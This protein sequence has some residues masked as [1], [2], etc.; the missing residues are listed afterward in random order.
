[1]GYFQS[2]QEAGLA[3][4]SPGMCKITINCFLENHILQ[5]CI[6]NIMQEMHVGLD[7]T[8]S[9]K[10][11]CTTFLAYI[12]TERLL[13][14]RVKF[15][16]Y[17]KLVRLNP[18]VPWKTRGNGA[19][20]LHFATDD[21][22]RVR[23][24]ITEMVLLYSDLQNGA[25][26]GVVFLEGDNITAHMKR[27]SQDALH[28][29]VKIS[30]AQ[31][32]IKQAG[33]DTLSLGTGMGIIGATAAIAYDFRDSTVEIITYRRDTNLGTQRHID[34]D[35][36]RM[37]QEKTFPYTF[38]SYDDDSG[39][40][41]IAPRGPDPVF[42][43]IRGEYPNILHR[44][45]SMIIHKERLRGHMIFRTNQGTGDHLQHIIKSDAMEPHTSGC[46]QGVVS[47][48]PQI[49]P[50]GHMC[51]NIHSKGISIPCWTY[52]PTKL[53][54]KL[55]GLICG[56]HLIVGGGVRAESVD[57]SRSINI[58]N[59]HVQRLAPHIT[60]RNPRCERC[61]KSMKSKGRG[62]HFWCIRCG[63]K[64]EHRQQVFIPR[65]ISEGEYS[66]VMTAH[67]H[68]TRPPQRHNKINRITFE[69]NTNWVA[70]YE[71]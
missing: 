58:E 31:S 6:T 64:A 20:A 51:F 70:V 3:L 2:Y 1:M 54:Q 48:E 59:V 10:G 69:P 66:A 60:Y 13:K 22:E 9:T 57:H 62:Q 7:D 36:V 55:S 23:Q 52:K 30:D 25:N 46:V 68:L 37:M 21:V 15:L 11:M 49:I 28:K 43:G 14:N 44:A 65:K 45:S 71:Y 35:S 41:L 50:G 18:N 33:G 53:P 17:P 5:Y 26:P 56:D 27:F 19:V 16:E 39:H 42:Y 34:P 40:V 12:I 67:R 32:I 8:D 63:D 29:I 47:S 24:H 38:N 61:N 4:N